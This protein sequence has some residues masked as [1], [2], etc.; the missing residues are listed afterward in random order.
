MNA[1]IAMMQIL[2]DSLMRIMNVNAFPITTNYQKKI[3]AIM[4]TIS[5]LKKLK[6]F[7]KKLQKN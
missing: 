7:K 1:I 3:Q 5:K 6:M 2:N 4:K